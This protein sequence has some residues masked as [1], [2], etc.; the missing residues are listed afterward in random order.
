MSRWRLRKSSREVI[1]VDLTEAPLKI[2]E[3]MRAERGLEN[4]SFRQ[5]DVEARLPFDDNEFDVVVCRF[6]VHHFA[7]SRDRHRRDGARVPS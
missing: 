4:V 6:A 5:G 7:E 3:R 1:G 2:A